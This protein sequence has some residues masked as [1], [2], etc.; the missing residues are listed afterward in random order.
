MRGNVE[1]HFHAASNITLI[2]AYFD[3]LENPLLCLFT[4]TEMQ[5]LVS[6]CSQ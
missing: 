6:T 1:V 3:V 4:E 2:K 5:I